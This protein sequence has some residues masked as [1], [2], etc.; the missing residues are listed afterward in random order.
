MHVD[1]KTNT[2]N[3]NIQGARLLCLQMVELHCSCI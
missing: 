1:I 2:G 3:Q